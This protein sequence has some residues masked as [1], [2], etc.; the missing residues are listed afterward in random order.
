MLAGP[1]RKLQLPHP[2]ACCKAE[3]PAA[4]EEGGFC[5]S[6]KAGICAFF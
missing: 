2:A 6:A 4:V 1:L 3:V 5:L